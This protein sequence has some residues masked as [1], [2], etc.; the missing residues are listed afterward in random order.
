MGHILWAS[1]R[2]VAS[3][4]NQF[5][6]CIRFLSVE[7]YLNVMK[8]VCHQNICCTYSTCAV[9]IHSMYCLEQ[10]MVGISIYAC[11]TLVSCICMWNMFGENW[12]DDTSRF[13]S[14]GVC[15]SNIVG[16]TRQPLRAPLSVTLFWPP[17]LRFLPDV[18]WSPSATPCSVLAA[19]CVVTSEAAST[20]FPRMSSVRDIRKATIAIG[21]IISAMSTFLYTS[22]SFENLFNDRRFDESTNHWR[23][24]TL[25]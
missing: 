10:M 14:C 7:I 23:G 25:W 4:D 19:S 8:H 11:K 22:V 5:K 21:M 15:N 9:N 17:L 13:S 6:C 20:F 18:L 1:N 12:D 2:V 3:V 16:S 24:K